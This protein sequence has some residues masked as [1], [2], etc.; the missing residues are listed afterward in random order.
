MARLL[1]TNTDNDLFVQLEWQDNAGAH[2]MRVTE[3]MPPAVRKKALDVIT[4]ADGEEKRNYAKRAETYSN[5][6]ALRQ[7]IGKLQAKERALAA[8]G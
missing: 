5:L 6:Q 1:I 2:T 7:E 4:W 8:R 3:D